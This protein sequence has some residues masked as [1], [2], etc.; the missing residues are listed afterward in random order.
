MDGVS[1]PINASTSN[2]ETSVQA[3]RQSRPLLRRL[4]V[5]IYSIIL[6]ITAFWILAATSRRQASRDW[7][8]S[9]WAQVHLTLFS[10]DASENVDYSA[11]DLF[12]QRVVQSERSVQALRRL[13]LL[14]FTGLVLAGGFIFAA[15]Q[16]FGAVK[17]S[18]E[19][20]NINEQISRLS[21][22]PVY[23]PQRTAEARADYEVVIPLEDEPQP[24]PQNEL[25]ASVPTE[26]FSSLS[27]FL[28]QPFRD[29]KIILVLASFVGACSGLAIG[30]RQGRVLST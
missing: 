14:L 29:S 25:N 21:E 8:R 17:Y 9:L 13:G 28:L 20:A 26:T 3:A 12:D 11:L 23:K 10:E 15:K 1:E 30:L 6:F 22:V 5:A 27:N 7:L 18:Y 16:H 24:L 19:T 2:V 4:I